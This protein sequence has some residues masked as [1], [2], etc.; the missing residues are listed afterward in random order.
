[1]SSS[2]LKENNSMENDTVNARLAMMDAQIKL[3]EKKVSFLSEV[4]RDIRTNMT[5]VSGSIEIAQNHRNDKEKVNEC[6]RK[7]IAAN[8]QINATLHIAG[9]FDDTASIYEEEED[10]FKAVAGIRI[11]LVEDNVVNL[12]ITQNMLEDSGLVVETAEDGLEALD[13]VVE[14]PD[15]YYDLIL[16]DIQMPVMDGFESADKIRKVPGMQKIPII[17]LSA[18]AFSSDKEKALEAGM[19]AYISKPI[20]IK[21]LLSTM[22]KLLL[23]Q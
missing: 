18:N 9:G 20:D 4:I 22:N 17:A 23:E 5:A 15:D 6:F 14:A 8:E 16:M 10:D 1:M 3:L 13:M 11:L 21:R 19:N 2:L 7:I 12:E